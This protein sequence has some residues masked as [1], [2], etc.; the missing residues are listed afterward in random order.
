MDCTLPGTG[1]AVQWPGRLTQCQLAGHHL[2]PVQRGG[3][4]QQ[5]AGHDVVEVS[6]WADRSNHVVTTGK[7]DVRV[8]HIG[9]TRSAHRAQQAAPLRLDR[10]TTRTGG[11]GLGWA[12]SL[13]WLVFGKLG[14][15]QDRRT[16]TH[17]A[18]YHDESAATI[19]RPLISPSEPASC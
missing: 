8:G 11:R 5:S 12:C 3:T 1:K 2:F 16:A 15:R 7:A 14:W 9:D 4:L 13:F 6:G 17:C 10:A 18:R 19:I